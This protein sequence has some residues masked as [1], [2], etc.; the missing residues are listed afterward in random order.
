MD[1]KRRGSP[2]PSAG[3]G[4]KE[5]ILFSIIEGRLCESEQEPERSRKRSH[6]LRNRAHIMPSKHVRTYTIKAAESILPIPTLSYL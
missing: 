4:E 6:P 3:I 1:G 2:A 5:S